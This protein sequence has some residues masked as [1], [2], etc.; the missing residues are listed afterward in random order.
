MTESTIR[1]IFTKTPQLKYGFQTKKGHPTY[2][3]I[4]SEI[5]TATLKN[6]VFEFYGITVMGTVMEINFNEAWK[7]GVIKI[8]GENE[9]I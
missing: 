7:D 8:V 5:Y 1:F 6:G 4:G 9:Y 2:P 3:R